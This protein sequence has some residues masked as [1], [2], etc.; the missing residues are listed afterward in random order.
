MYNQKLKT[1]KKWNLLSAGVIALA[2]VLSSCSE[3]EDPVEI[4]ITQGDL[5]G[6]INPIATVTGGSM[7]HAGALVT[8]ADSTIREVFSNRT[9][10]DGNI[11]LGTIVTKNTYKKNADGS[12]GDLLLSFAMVK[13]ESGYDNENENWE[14]TVSPFSESVDYE[15]HPFGLLPDVGNVDA[16]GALT[17]C[18]SCH[19]GAGGGDYLFIND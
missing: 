13:R 15:A 19:A 5:D 14:Y 17:S 9:S 6:S 3:D 10:L 1:M 18:V 11:S 16:R 2:M 4:L 7:A 8:N 12:K